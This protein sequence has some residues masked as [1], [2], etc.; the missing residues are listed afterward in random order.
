MIAETFQ[1]STQYI[2][3]VRNILLFTHLRAYKGQAQIWKDEDIKAI[4]YIDKFK[5]DL[6]GVDPK[7]FS[8]SVGVLLQAEK[9]YGNTV[10]WFLET[11]RDL[12][13][14]EVLRAFGFDD[15]EGLE[16]EYV[17]DDLD[18]DLEDYPQNNNY[19]KSFP[20]ITVL[21]DGDKLK[22]LHIYPNNFNNE[23]KIEDFAWLEKN[24]RAF[25]GG[26]TIDQK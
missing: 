7:R 12:S 4:E 3:Y 5:G 25:W 17:A 18:R 10:Y 16:D 19:P 6:T 8:D 21:G 20:V 11:F 2:Q 9:E 1:N 26:E 24:I 22:V 23:V 13:S 14:G 15:L